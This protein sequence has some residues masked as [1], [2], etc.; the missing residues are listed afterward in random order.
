[1]T[2]NNSWDSVAK[3]YNQLIRDSG[4]V[5]HST[6]LNPLVLKLLGNVKNR[7]ILDLACGNGY[8]SKIL[9]NDGAIVTAV[10]YSKEFISIAKENANKKISFFVG[11]SSNLIFLDDN[12][13]DSIIS[14]VA[15]HD[16]K[17]IS[18][19]INE[20]SRLIKPNHKLIFS[21]P[22]PAFHLSK[23]AKEN[24]EYFKKVKNYVSLMTVDHHYFKGVKHYHRPIEYYCKLLFK[25]Q[26]IIS[27]FYEITTKHIGGKIIKYAK[28]L[29][30]KQ[31]IPTFLIIEATSVK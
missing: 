1:M 13:F 17:D 12:C 23:R 11:S 24:N 21:I 16:I 22:H 29:R 27:G 28:L 25:N 10:D 14:N 8:F 26:F 9:A 2:K 3:E 31:E 5:Y 18:K 6:Y 4:D 7:K 30:H 19:T 20:C 15:F